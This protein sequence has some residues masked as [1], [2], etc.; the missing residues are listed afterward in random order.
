[1]LWNFFYCHFHNASKE[2]KHYE[3]SQGPP[4]PGFMKEKVQKGDFLK[5]GTGDLNFVLG[6]SESL[7]GLD[8]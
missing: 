8:C 3:N 2:W 6:S 7:E 1:M 5:K 4:N